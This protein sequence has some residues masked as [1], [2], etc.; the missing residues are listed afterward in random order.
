MI[1][2]VAVLSSMILGSLNHVVC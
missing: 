2:Y 1:S